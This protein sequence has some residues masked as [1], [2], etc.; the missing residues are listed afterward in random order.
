M[1]FLKKSLSLFGLL[2]LGWYECRHS[3]SSVEQKTE[4][5]VEVNNTEKQRLELSLMTQM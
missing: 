5:A 3:N 2:S 1:R 4:S